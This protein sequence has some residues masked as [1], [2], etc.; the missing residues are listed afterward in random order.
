MLL[1][2]PQELIDLIL[3]HLPKKS[4][5]ACALVASSLLVPSQRLIFR[6]LA[7]NNKHIPKAHS[8]L[9]TTSHIPA[10]VR[11]LQVALHASLHSA[12]D[13][14]FASILAL[15]PNLKAFFLSGCDVEWNQMSLSLQTALHNL[16]ASTEIDSLKLT[17]M[18]NVPTSFIASALAFVRRLHLFKIHVL[19]SSEE[20]HTPSHSFTPRA[21]HLILRPTN[22]ASLQS[23]VNSMLQ[24]G[25]RGL[26]KKV[27]RLTV[28][29]RIQMPRMISATSSSLRYLRI[30]CG[31]DFALDELPSLPVLKV[32]ELTMTLD[33]LTCLPLTIYGA[34]AAFPA[35]IPAIEVVHLRFW[36]TLVP[37]PEDMQW[38]RDPRG[39]LPVFDDA[40]YQEKLPC[41]RRVYCHLWWSPGSQDPQAEFRAYIDEK[42]PALRDTGVLAISAEPTPELQ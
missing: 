33:H 10:Y 8:L 39:P 27:Q 34:V 29:S 30:L 24:C 18:R 20:L 22:S 31:A 16:L 28:Q 7:L 5:R 25:T 42:F 15:L 40:A 13:D 32:L 38:K 23:M 1:K 19:E 26:L 37:N 14:V 9:S 4:L 21:Q 17:N 6:S 11:T 35:T 3:V 41:L 2:L 12:H 36:T